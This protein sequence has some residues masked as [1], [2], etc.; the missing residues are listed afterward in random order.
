MGVG[1]GA[2]Y[3][4]VALVHAYVQAPGMPGIY[5][6]VLQLIIVGFVGLVPGI[7]GFAIGWGVDLAV[8]KKST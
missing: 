2:A 3:G 1:A 7:L 5:E 8:K 4:V 6:L